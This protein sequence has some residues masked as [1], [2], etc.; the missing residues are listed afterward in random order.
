MCS[1]LSLAPCPLYGLLQH[2]AACLSLLCRPC[3]GTGL[4]ECLPSDA[5]LLL[6]P[7]LCLGCLVTVLLQQ[8]QQQQ[9]GET[10]RRRLPA[11]DKLSSC[12]EW[13]HHAVC[14]GCLIALLL[15]MEAVARSMALLEPCAQCKIAVLLQ[16]NGRWSQQTVLQ[17]NSDKQGKQNLQGGSYTSSPTRSDARSGGEEDNGLQRQITQSHPPCQ[18][19]DQEMMTLRIDY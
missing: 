8:Q 4:M 19:L 7:G 3:M 10:S 17:K 6:H 1:A 18:T 5:V 12:M 9:K 14:L 16:Q 15:A 11:N 13:L 2:L